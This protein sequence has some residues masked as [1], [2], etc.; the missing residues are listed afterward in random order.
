MFTGDIPPM[1]LFFIL[2][3][4]DLMGVRTSTIRKIYGN[5]LRSNPVLSLIPIKIK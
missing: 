5:I 4:T 3:Q 2:Y 1:K